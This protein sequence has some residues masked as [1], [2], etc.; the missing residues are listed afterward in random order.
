MWTP[1]VGGI[2]FSMEEA[3]AG[4]KVGVGTADVHSV[5]QIAGA[6]SG[7]GVLLKQLEEEIASAHV[8]RELAENAA[9]LL[10]EEALCLREEMQQVAL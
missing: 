3:L 10:E 1:R 2:K 7:V 5:R 9:L 6:N 8:E 4:L